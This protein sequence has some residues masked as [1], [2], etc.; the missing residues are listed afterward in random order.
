MSSWNSEF[1]GEATDTKE[2]WRRMQ[3]YE[4]HKSVRSKRTGCPDR[5]EKGSVSIARSQDR[6]HLT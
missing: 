6:W 1:S 3:V 2:V 5:I 4:S